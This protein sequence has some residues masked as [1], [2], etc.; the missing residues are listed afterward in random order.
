MFKVFLILFAV[1]VQGQTSF[2]TE[3]TNCIIRFAKPLEKNGNFKHY[4]LTAP[5]CVE[6]A[7]GYFLKNYSPRDRVEISFQAQSGMELEGKFSIG[8]H[9]GASGTCK[10]IYSTANEDLKY[11]E[12][13]A[14]TSMNDC[15]GTAASILSRNQGKVPHA[16]V[17]YDFGDLRIEGNITAQKKSL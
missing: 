4:N 15:F 5:Q 14:T 16:R 13:T 3:P 2:A 12:T 10:V 11:G 6:R 9:W 7:I 1:V 17:H 8:P